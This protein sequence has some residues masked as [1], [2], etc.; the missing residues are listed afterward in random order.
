MN[1][2]KEKYPLLFRNEDPME[3]INMFGI[4]CS[5]G[6]NDLLNSTFHL[7]HA[8]YKAKLN[9]V[10]FWKKK[11]PDDSYSRE[12][13]DE[14]IALYEEELKQA[15]LE[16]PIVE[17][18]KEKF[19]TLRL[20]CSNTN[21]YSKGVIDMAETMSASICEICGGGG[22]LSG[23]RWVSTLCPP[24]AEKRDNRINEAQ[25]VS[26]NEIVVK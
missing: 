20:Y 2:F 4:E 23:K 1:I 11:D 19:G 8:K 9:E 24:C 14:Y 7:L 3:P 16:V 21:D 25:N 13:I 17:Q 6:W 18:C 26:N 15:E 12:K 5:K 10:N 22:K